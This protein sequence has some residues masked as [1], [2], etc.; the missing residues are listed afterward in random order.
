MG[1]VNIYIYFLYYIYITLFVLEHAYIY[2]YVYTD[3]QHV[4][5]H[6]KTKV[7]GKETK[8]IA[9]PNDFQRSPALVKKRPAGE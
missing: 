5:T 8:K 9:G 7:W 2:I 6:G 4:S 1:G 3:K